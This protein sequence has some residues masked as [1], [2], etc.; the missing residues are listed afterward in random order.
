MKRL[1]FLL[2]FA[3]LFLTAA[4]AQKVPVFTVEVSSDSILVGNYFMVRFTLENASSKD[5]QPPAFDDFNIISGPNMSSSM[6]SINGEVSQKVSYTFYLEPKDIGNFYIQPASVNTGEN[7]LETKPLLIMVV[8]NPDGLIQQPKMEERFD[9]NWQM[10][11]FFT[12][13]TMPKKEDEKP[14][15]KTRKTYKI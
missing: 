14:R 1:L 7:T 3:T 2:V 8:P 4:F 10:D 15:K 13:P 5:F 6:T 12:P 11:N 9:L